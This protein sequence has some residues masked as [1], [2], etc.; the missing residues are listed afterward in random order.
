MRRWR[1]W[2]ISRHMYIRK[3]SDTCI[4]VLLFFLKLAY[5]FRKQILIRD[6]YFCVTRCWSSLQTA[7]AAKNQFTV[8]FLGVG[9][10]VLCESAARRETLSCARTKSCFGFSV[11]QHNNFTAIGRFPNARTVR[12]VHMPLCGRRKMYL[13]KNFSATQIRILK[14]QCLTDRWTQL[15]IFYGVLVKDSWLKL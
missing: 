11:Q 2:Q 5:R 7:R 4:W 8:R 3:I 10:L 13:T 14:T 1:G 6:F 9:V 12:R 15:K